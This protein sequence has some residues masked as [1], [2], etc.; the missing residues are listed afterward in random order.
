M[1]I[2]RRSFAGLGPLSLSRLLRASPSTPGS[3]PATFRKLE[4]RSGGR[5]GVAVLNTATGE[6]AYHRAGERFPMCSTF[7][8]LLVS[9]VL[10]RVD[11]REETLDR[12]VAIPPKPLLAHSPLTEPHAGGTMTAAALCHAA[13]TQSDNTAANLLLEGIG[14]P[15][16]ITEFARSIGDAVT[17]L[18]RT[19]PELN[20]ALANDPRDTTSPSAMAADLKSVLLGNVLSPA[21]RE[22]LTRWMEANVTGA[23]RLRAQLPQAWRAADKTGSNG[24]HTTNDIAV[25]WPPGKRPIV[26]AAYITRCAGPESKR[27]AMLAEIGRAVA[28]SNG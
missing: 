19:E 3:L 4:Q 15:A 1:T 13:L 5:L 9:A 20:E 28:E 12:T 8:F 2:S 26:I 22:Q 18:D 16:G 14:G 27:S 11:R 6:S 24:K 17:R 10:R 23:D 21:S 7:K 25:V